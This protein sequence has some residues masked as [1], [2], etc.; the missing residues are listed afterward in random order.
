MTVS[1]EAIKLLDDAMAERRAKLYTGAPP[2][3]AS[4]K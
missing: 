4:A 2:A 1:Q 3:T